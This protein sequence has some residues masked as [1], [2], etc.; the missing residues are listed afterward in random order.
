MRFAEFQENEDVFRY[1]MDKLGTKEKKNARLVCKKWEE[2]LTSLLAVQKVLIIN[3]DYRSVQFDFCD[4]NLVGNEILIY[5]RYFDAWKILKSF[6]SLESISLNVDPK[7]FINVLNIISH[8]CPNITCISYDN[9]IDGFQMRY[10][11]DIFGDKLKHFK[12]NMSY[13][14]T[15]KDFSYFIENLKIIEKLTIH[16]NPRA[17][18]ID[19]KCFSTLRNFTYLDVSNMEDVFDEDFPR[20]L[21]KGIRNCGQ[22]ETLYLPKS[23]LQCIDLVCENFQKLLSLEFGVA[24]G[25][26]DNFY[27]L[28]KLANLRN[29][30]VKGSTG[31]DHSLISLF[32]SDVRLVYL[33][34]I[35]LPLTDMSLTKLSSCRTIEN[36]ILRPSALN[37][38]TEKSFLKFGDLPLRYFECNENLK[39]IQKITYPK[40]IRLCNTLSLFR[41]EVK[42]WPF[43]AYIMSS[44]KKIVRNLPNKVYRLITPN[45]TMTIQKDHTQGYQEVRE[46][47][48]VARQ[49]HGVGWGQDG[50]WGQDDDWVQVEDP[51]DDF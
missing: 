22:L 39:H 32:K 35:D 7:C 6:P 9:M 47:Y 5:K 37:G 41:L 8:L 1:L 26:G 42:T 48:H 33:A 29:L 24:I 30:I 20:S 38:I 25:E 31:F 27:A 11:V 49:I 51:E 14:F 40:F 21:A 16:K 34:L 43:V 50:G 45:G 18:T 10:F 4:H 44:M 17:Q 15:K 3:T 28:N 13:T 2:V 12:I 46:R 36:L 19:L 23:T